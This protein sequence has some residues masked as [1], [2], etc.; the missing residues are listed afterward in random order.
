MATYSLTVVNDSELADGSP[1]FS[2]VAELPEA[3]AGNALS[4]AWLTQVI[5]PGNR[6]TFTWDV[7]WGF[8][9]SAS[10]TA[11]DY[12]WRAN[13]GISADPTSSSLCAATFDYTN[14]DFELTHATHTPS[15]DHDH[16]YIQDTRAIPKPSVQPSSLGITLN[17]LPACVVDAGP[18]LQHI[19]T[20][21]PTYYIVAGSFKQSQMVDVATLT[22]TQ[23][24]SY[25]TGVADLTAVLDD[26]NNWHVTHSTEA[27]LAAAMQP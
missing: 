25:T 18:N 8:A 15:P 12:Q 26:E 21:H 22:Q 7:T 6:Y 10:G 14:G 2:V 20:L 13:G 1:A 19:A 4:T 11:K 24:L 27:D 16:L 23:I 5:H 17:G 9:W 3:R